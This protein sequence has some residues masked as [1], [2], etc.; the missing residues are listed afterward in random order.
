MLKIVEIKRL[1]KPNTL[2]ENRRKNSSTLKKPTTNIN[3]EY[4][5][6]NCFVKLFEDKNINNIIQTLR[7]SKRIQNY[8]TPTLEKIKPIKISLAPTLRR[9]KRLQKIM[10]TVL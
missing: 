9:S 3:C 10:S 2:Q 7:R 8:L 6:Q 4:E 1:T 5:M